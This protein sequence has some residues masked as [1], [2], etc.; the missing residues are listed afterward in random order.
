ML[1]LTTG[2]TTIPSPSG[3]QPSMANRL[4]SQDVAAL[5]RALDSQRL[6]AR[7]AQDRAKELQQALDGERSAVRALRREAAAHERS[8]REEEG[9]KYSDQLEQ[10][11]NK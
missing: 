7:S 6:S 11:K 8:V 3:R 2:M 10:L 5:Q 9:R 4:R 1:S